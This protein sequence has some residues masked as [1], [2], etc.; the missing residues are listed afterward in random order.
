MNYSGS[1]NDADPLLKVLDIAANDTTTAVGVSS[2]VGAF[3]RLLELAKLRDSDGNFYKLLIRNDGGVIYE[4]FREK[5]DYYRYPLPRGLELPGGDTP[6]WEAK[7]GIIRYV[8]PESGPE[9]PDTW[10]ND[11]RHNYYERAVMRDGDAVA[12]F[13]GRELDA[14]DIYRAAEANQRWIESN[15]PVAAPKP[16]KVVEPERDIYGHIVPPKKGE[17]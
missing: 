17:G 13:H 4:K 15:R 1:S 14:L 10:L 11:R 8:D 6:T 3:D 7:P 16:P 12:T 9:L 2:N 5:P